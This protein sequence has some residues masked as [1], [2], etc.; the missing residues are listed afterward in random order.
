MIPV[1]SVPLLVTIDSGTGYHAKEG[2]NCIF[3][4]THRRDNL[5]KCAEGGHAACIL[6]H[7]A[8]LKC[9]PDVAPDSAQGIDR[10]SDEPFAPLR[11]RQ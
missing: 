1:E 3:R 11:F 4:G 2:A 10:N 7:V 6:A 9:W 5:G 8:A